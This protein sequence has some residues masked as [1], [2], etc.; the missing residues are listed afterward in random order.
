LIVI[1]IYISG[2]PVVSTDPTKSQISLLS[3]LTILNIGG[4]PSKAAGIFTMMFLLYTT[5]CLFLI[6]FYWKKS[7][8]WRYR[9]HSH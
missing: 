1:P 5:F 4:K 8:K 2:D 7:T 3:R 9:Q 6:F